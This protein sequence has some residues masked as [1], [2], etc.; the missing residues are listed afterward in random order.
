MIAIRCPNC[1][2][3]ALQKN[4]RTTTGQQKYHCKACN[5][6]GTLDT[7]QAE[8]ERQQ[9]LVEQLHHARVSQRGIARITGVSRTTIIKWLKKSYS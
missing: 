7:R 5:R 9:Q 2:S 4:G 1:D 3:P 6:Y 8:R